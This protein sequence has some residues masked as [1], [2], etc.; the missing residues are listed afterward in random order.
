MTFADIDTD[1]EDEEDGGDGGDGGDRDAGASDDGGDDDDGPA[2][3]EG[4]DAPPPPPLPPPRQHAAAT[5]SFTQ[6]ETDHMPARANREEEIREW[7]RANSV[8]KRNPAAPAGD[9]EGDLS[10]RHPMFIKDKADELFR[11]GD[12]AAAVRM[13]NRC[14]AIDGGFAPALNNRSCCFFRMGSYAECEADCTGVME[15]LD[16][17]ARGAEGAAR[18]DDAHAAI[19]AEKL[20][21][22]LKRRGLARAMM[23]GRGEC[24][25]S[26]EA[27]ADL[28]AA[29]RTL[30]GDAE[31]EH[32]IM[33]LEMAVLDAPADGG[34]G[35]EAIARR[36]HALGAN[37]LSRGDFSGAGEAF[38][39]AIG[40]LEDDDG[41]EDDGAGACAAGPGPGEGT[42]GGADERGTL[43]A[44]CLVNRATAF[45]QQGRYHR[46]VEDAQAVLRS[47]RG[48]ERRPP[49]GSLIPRIEAMALSRRGLAQCNLRLYEEAIASLS[50]SRAIFAELGVEDE[51]ARIAED[52]REV[53]SKLAARGREAG[54]GRAAAE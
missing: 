18:E 36:M 2:E 54:G 25:R 49:D 53:E 41:A 20:A 8:P 44:R 5:V 12:Y 15:L 45:L 47:I 33:E 9:D 23:T 4:V 30:R 34:A 43:R 14:L 22:M 17:G 32:N 27:L 7:K 24:D 52:M 11:H 40:L 1:T 19:R 42:P 35:A 37:R 13:Y 21:K 46:C 51:A 48:A 6:L 16:A 29:M 10:A 38:T 28:R 26:T 3:G 39:S 31:L 50:A